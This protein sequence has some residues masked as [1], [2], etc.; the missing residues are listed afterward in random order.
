VVINLGTNDI[1]NNKGDPPGFEAA[2][3]GLLQTIRGRYPNAY[4]LCIIG[5]LLSGTDLTTIQGHIRAAVAARNAA[6]DARVSFFDQ[7]AAQ[8]SDKFACQYHPN[9]A[10][11][12]LMGMQLA[13]ELAARLG[14]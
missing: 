8:T 13:T 12:M 3:G 5:P 2:Y 4:I 7:I 14:W 9:V 11:N 1:S 10:E 6:G